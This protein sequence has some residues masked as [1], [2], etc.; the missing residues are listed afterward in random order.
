MS[1]RMVLLVLLCSTGWWPSVFSVGSPWWK[2]DFRGGAC[3]VIYNKRGANQSGWIHAFF[4][5]MLGIIVMG[6]EGVESM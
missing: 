5:L 6:K 4:Y 3:H 2:L 1:W